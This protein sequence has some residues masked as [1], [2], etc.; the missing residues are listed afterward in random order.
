MEHATITLSCFRA[1]KL[2]IMN[3]EFWFIG[4]NSELFKFVKQKVFP[5]IKLLIELLQSGFFIK[6]IAKINYKQNQHRADHLKSKHCCIITKKSFYSCFCYCSLIVS[7]H[8][9][10]FVR[11]ILTICSLNS[12]YLKKNITRILVIVLGICV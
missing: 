8:Y 11:S 7:F 2:K 9:L 1:A 6:P 12:S 10:K 3:D 5:L 4:L